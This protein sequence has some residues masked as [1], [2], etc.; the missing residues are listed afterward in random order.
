M[1]PIQSG[2]KV[3]NQSKLAKLLV[4]IDKRKA[5]LD[6]DYSQLKILQENCVHKFKNLSERSRQCTKCR[7][8]DYWE[9][10]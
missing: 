2:K 9:M 4:R 5:A 8:Y 1:K 7:R 3:A 6:R 10:W